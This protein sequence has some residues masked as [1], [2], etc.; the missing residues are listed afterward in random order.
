MTV[1]ELKEALTLDNS[2]QTVSPDAEVYLTSGP[3]Q[4]W[5]I[6]SLFSGERNSIWIEIAK[7]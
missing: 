4:Y 2:G 1:A 3:V 7:D 5:R 6:V